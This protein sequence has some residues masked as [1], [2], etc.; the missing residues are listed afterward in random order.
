MDDRFGWADDTLCLG[1]SGDPKWMPVTSEFR[2][3]EMMCSM[4]TV[5][6]NGPGG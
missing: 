1:R 3:L 5:T 2:Q 6:V 4:T